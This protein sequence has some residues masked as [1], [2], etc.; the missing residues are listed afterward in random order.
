MADIR[1]DFTKFIKDFPVDIIP[2][3]SDGE[4]MERSRKHKMTMLAAIRRN[5]KV[6]HERMRS[7]WDLAVVGS[8]VV[9]GAGGTRG[10]FTS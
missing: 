2:H 9:G 8:D 3:T 7:N 10:S 1:R 4:L 5:P 6:P